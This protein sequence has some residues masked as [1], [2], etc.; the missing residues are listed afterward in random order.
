MSISE[1]AAEGIVMVQH[2]YGDGEEVTPKGR[3]A[4]PVGL[5]P[6]LAVA[7][8]ALPRGG[9]ND[10]VFLRVVRQCRAKG[11]LKPHTPNTITY[12][13]NKLQE[14]AG[15]D[16]SGPHRLRHTGLTILAAKGTN[17]YKLQKHAR[18][19]KLETTQGYVH[20]AAEQAA[21]EVAAM[22]GETCAQNRSQSGRRSIGSENRAGSTFDDVS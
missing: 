11:Q 14:A 10:H 2:N 9:K 1:Y 13:L 17:P 4:A 21:R 3:E 6:D 8:R 5:S 18:H 12:K 16:R 15:L 7:L 19:S 22:W 20:L